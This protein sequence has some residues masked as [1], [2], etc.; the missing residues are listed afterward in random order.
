MLSLELAMFGIFMAAFQFIP[1]I[2]IIFLPLIILLGFILVLGLNLA[3]STLNVRYRDIQFIWAVVLQAGFFLTP[4]F[5]KLE[6]LPE[7]VQNVLQF[8]P[9]VQI[10]TMARDV[11]LYNVI[12]STESIMIAIGSTLLVFGICYGIFRKMR[13][14]IVE[15]L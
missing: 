4:I 7:N 13:D 6:M 10:V 14:K 12:P 3:L 5:Y 9:M 1:P 2:T 15:E 8:F 11:T